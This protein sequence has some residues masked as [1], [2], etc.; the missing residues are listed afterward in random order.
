MAGQGEVTIVR[1]S[2]PATLVE[3]RDAGRSITR[4]YLA[5]T[6]DEKGCRPH[7]QPTD[8]EK[9]LSSLA[10]RLGLSRFR[11]FYL[12]IPFINDGKLSVILFILIGSE[13]KTKLEPQ[14]LM[15]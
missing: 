2:N 1:F 3:H 6:A 13:L 8:Y 11:S 4:H 12:N 5:L 14:N 15:I 7:N 10:I 9:E